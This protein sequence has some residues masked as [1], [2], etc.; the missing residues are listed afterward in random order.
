MRRRRFL[1]NALSASLLPALP[2]RGDSAPGNTP[3]LGLTL[4]SY[5][6]RWRNRK[7]AEKRPGWENALDVLDHCRELGA[8]C[9]QIGVRGWTSDFAGR[10]RDRREDC[11]I[12]LEGQIGL[13]R[14]EVDVL[15]SFR[16]ARETLGFE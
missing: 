6:I 8:G 3:R 15:R 16:Y 13:P 10:V 5:Q 2:T 7:R 11:G 4:W 9:L 14:E 1:T 12:A